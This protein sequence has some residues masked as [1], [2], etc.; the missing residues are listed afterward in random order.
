M[1][2]VI[3]EVAKKLFDWFDDTSEMRSWKTANPLTKEKY[4][5]YAHRLSE[6]GLLREV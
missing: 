3:E 1:N 6:A 4:Y 5:Y 2:E